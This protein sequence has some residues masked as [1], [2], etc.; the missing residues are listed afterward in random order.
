MNTRDSSLAFFINQLDAFDTRLHEPLLSVTWSRDI[1]LRSGIS[2]GNQ[3][4]SFVRGEFGANGSLTA[5]GKAWLGSGARGAIGSVSVDGVPVTLP[6]NI[7]GREIRYTS[8]ELERSQ[9]AGQNIDDAQ[10]KALIASYNA[11]IDEMVYIGDTTLGLKGLLNSTEVGA[12]NVVAGAATTL[13]W[14]TKTADEILFDVNDAIKA[15]WAAS[16]YA[17]CPDVLLIPP[18]QYALITGKKAGTDG[19][20]GSILKYLEDNSMSLMINGRPLSVRPCKWC[21]GIGGSSSDRMVAYNES[22]AYVRYP[23]APIQRQQAYYQGIT[24]AAPYVAGLGAV[25]FLYPET[26]IYRD[27]I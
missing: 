4:T 9:M 11:D 22:D 5:T 14:S 12:S 23:L 19:A 10:T 18:T 25:E 17:V 3:S 24:F 21:V 20:G 15:A 16:A 7:W 2:L 6:L 8:V 13:P 26:A 27:G 1:K